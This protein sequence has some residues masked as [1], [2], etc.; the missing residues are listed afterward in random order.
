MG[1]LFPQR[2]L[3]IQGHVGLPGRLCRW[4]PWEPT[5]RRSRVP[6]AAAQGAGPHPS[7]SPRWSLR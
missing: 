5:G 7:L 3:K 1:E 6:V 2:S 4:S